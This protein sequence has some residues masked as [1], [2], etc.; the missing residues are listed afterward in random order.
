MST[1]ETE[2]LVAAAASSAAGPP[3]TELHL[4]LEGA[5]SA[6][7]ALSWIR[8]ATDVP[9]AFSAGVVRS[10]DGVRWSFAG[11]GEFLRLFG[12]ATRLLDG[13]ERYE[14]LLGDLLELLDIQGIRVAEVFVAVGQMQRAGTDPLPVLERL[15]ARA[16]ACE[17]AGGCSVWFVADATRQW[18]VAAA[19]RVLDAAL[20]ARAF[21]V[22]GFG[23][24]GDE[25]AIRAR[26]FREIYRRAQAE[27]LGSSCHAGEG[28]N[29]DA[30]REAV[31]ELGVRRVGHGIAAAYDESLMRALR[32]EGI[33]LEVC[34]TSNQ[35]TGVWDPRTGEHPVLRLLRAGVPVVI[36][37]DDPAFFDCTLRS[38]FE[39]LRR[40][41]VDEETLKAIDARAAAARFSSGDCPHEEGGGGNPRDRCS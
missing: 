19:E 22:V 38:E 36:G 13:P 2:R 24:G 21:R 20:R 35:R 14:A 32:E 26:A 25:G 9:P 5:L 6:S 30:V 4:H 27:G 7:R 12:A 39:R 29:P 18:G 31:E 41:G 40:W 15:A 34:P 8:A 33:V 11:L 3:T 10:E 1:P 17:E 28:T 37:S 23:M 16:R